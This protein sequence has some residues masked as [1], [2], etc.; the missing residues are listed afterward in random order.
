MQLYSRVQQNRR[1]QD[2]IA[3]LQ[4]Q[5]ERLVVEYEQ[6]GR[7]ARVACGQNGRNLSFERYVLTAYFTQIIAAANLRLKRMTDSRYLL[8]RKEEK[9]KG[10]SASGLGLAIIDNYT[11]REREVGT[12]S[13]GD[14]IQNHAGGVRIETMFIDE[15]FGTLDPAS[16]DGAVDT[17]MR[18]KNDGRLV[19]VISHVPELRERIPARIEI[20]PS[21][22]GSSIRMPGV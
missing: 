22:S 12:L 19:G 3:R 17:L 7:L 18:L 15:G 1:Q 11:G 6:V 9:E 13:G 4:E 20:V 21:K 14:V 5:T 8:K 10:N 2:N 16:L